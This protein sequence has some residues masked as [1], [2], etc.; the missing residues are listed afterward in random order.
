[1]PRMM[2]VWT[3]AT[4]PVWSDLRDDRARC[5]A[6]ASRGSARSR[7]GRGRRSWTCPTTCAEERG[8]D[9]DR[10]ASGTGRRSSRRSRESTIRGRAGR[11]AGARTSAGRARTRSRSAARRKFRWWRRS[12]AAACRRGAPLTSRARL[13][14]GSEVASGGVEV[15]VV[16][17][18][19][20]TVTDATRDA[21]RL[22]RRQDPGNG[23][24]RR[25]RR[26]RA[27]CRP[28]TTTSSTSPSAAT[29]AAGVVGAPVRELERDRVAAQLALERVR[30]A[31][32]DDPAAVDDRERVG[33]LVGL[34]EVV[35]RQQDRQLSCA[36]QSPSSSHIAAR[37]SGSSPVVGSS[38]KSTC[39]RCTR[40][41]A[42]SSRRFMPPE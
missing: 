16:E 15:D 41:I 27:A 18:R 20:A 4:I 39:G 37:A 26:G 40:P 33:E 25:S 8:H 36:R 11:R 7:P 22:E 6:P 9:H 32:G 2:T 10:P 17:R 3:I 28:S 19:P 13:V 34:L 21:L 24:R 38:R 35:R 1:M 42:T 30:R 12:I 29:I 31:L 14:L 5:G 23:A